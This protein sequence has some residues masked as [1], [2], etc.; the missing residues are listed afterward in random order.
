MRG[1]AGLGALLLLAGCSHDRPD[2]PPPWSLRTAAT[3]HLQALAR[4]GERNRG[5]RAA[6][7]PGYDASVDYV[8]GRLRSAGYRVRLQTVN[9][10]L[11][12]P[13]P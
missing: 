5:T 8:A 9:R 7:T 12:K 10:A 4:I 13:A 6:G 11:G 2:P 1:L 3:A